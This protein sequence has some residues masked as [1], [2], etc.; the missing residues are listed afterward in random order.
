M[1]IGIKCISSS[2]ITNVSYEIVVKDN[3]Y[4]QI[5]LGITPSDMKTSIYLIVEVETEDE[6]TAYNY[7]D[8]LE[9]TL[10]AIIPKEMPD[11]AQCYLMC[12]GK[13]GESC[14]H[15]LTDGFCF[16]RIPGASRKQYKD[17]LHIFALAKRIV[18][19]S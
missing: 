13:Y 19:K 5:Y 12:R 14:S 1:P 11:A 16:P 10:N 4:D 8:K 2:E 9:E 17:I 18:K 7:L 3:I 6:D 15:I